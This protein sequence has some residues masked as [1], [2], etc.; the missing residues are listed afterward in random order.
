VADQAPSF[1]AA[2]LFVVIARSDAT[3]RSIA[4][5]QAWIAS[6]RSQ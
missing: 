5:P 1:Y 3:K 6:L 2:P 4:V